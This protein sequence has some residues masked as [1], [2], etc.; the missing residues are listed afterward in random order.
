MFN[1]INNTHQCSMDVKPDVKT[2]HVLRDHGIEI[3]KSLRE[4]I[5]IPHVKLYNDS[6][7]LFS[8][9]CRS[10]G[11]ILVGGDEYNVATRLEAAFKYAELLNLWP[12]CVQVPVG[13]WP[14]VVQLIDSF[15][16]PHQRINCV[17]E[18]NDRKGSYANK[19]SKIFKQCLKI[20]NLNISTKPQQADIYVCEYNMCGELG[21]KLHYSE[22]GN[23]LPI[24]RA[25]VRVVF[26]EAVSFGDFYAIYQ[27]HF[28]NAPEHI[29]NAMSRLEP[30]NNAMAYRLYKTLK[31][32]GILK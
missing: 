26:H 28:P 27:A 10:G 30:E 1:S 15:R 19:L 2:L 18:N 6:M 14:G 22:M 13:T 31:D 12:L 8:E 32:E 29:A 5:D 17:C 23:V 24:S 21:I 3:D 20:T 7:S 11:E 9:L 16:K 25:F 4:T